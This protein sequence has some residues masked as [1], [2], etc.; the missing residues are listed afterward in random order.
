MELYDVFECFSDSRTKT[1]KMKDLVHAIVNLGLADKNPT[2]MGIIRSIE[3]DYGDNALDFDTFLG[4]ITARL[5]NPGTLDGRRTIFNIVDMEKKGAIS[6]ENLKQLAREIGY[7]IS[8]N[9]IQEVI[10]SISPNSDGIS[11]E[12]YERHMSRKYDDLQCYSV[13]SAL[14]VSYLHSL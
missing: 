6:F 1:L 8:D 13:L 2:L 7:N 14:G 5:G 3:R 4:E 11:F 10:Q 12:D 9:E